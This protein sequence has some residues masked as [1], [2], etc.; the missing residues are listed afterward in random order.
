M[1]GR[2]HILVIEDNAADVRLMREALRDLDPPVDLHVASDGEEAL[3]FLGRSGSHA[4]APVPNLI[5]LDFN[6]PKSEPRDL[7]RH[8]KQDEYLRLIPVAVLTTSDAAKDVRD[9]IGRAS[10]RERV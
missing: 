4:G 5:F 2:R 3:L 7:L 8:L 6:L 1:S 10:C 9:E